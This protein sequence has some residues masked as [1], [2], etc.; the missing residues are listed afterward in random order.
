MDPLV[1]E[2]ASRD[3]PAPHTHDERHPPHERG[4]QYVSAGL[5]RYV[6]MESALVIPPGDDAGKVAS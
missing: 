6:T 3:I 1:D 2:R 4:M 5:L